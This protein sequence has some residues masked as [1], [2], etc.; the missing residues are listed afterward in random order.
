MIVTIETLDENQNILENVE[1]KI[2][3]KEKAD[4][5]KVE[6]VWRNVIL[7]SNLHIFAV[8]GA[9]IIVKYAKWQNICLCNS[10]VDIDGNPGGVH[11]YWAHRSFKSK[12]TTPSNF[13][14]FANNGASK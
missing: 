8:Y 5:Y 12:T 6:I 4:C 7:L 13:G 9:Y 2:E 1:T 14:L 11:R 3:K 10:I